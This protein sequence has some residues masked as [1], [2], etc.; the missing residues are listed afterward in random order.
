VKRHCPKL[1]VFR[2][3]ANRSAAF[4]SGSLGFSG[5]CF[6]LWPSMVQG[7]AAD[8]M[9]TGAFTRFEGRRWARPGLTQRR[10]VSTLKQ[11]P[12]SRRYGCDPGCRAW[13]PRRPTARLLPIDPRTD[14]VEKRER[15]EGNARHNEENPWPRASGPSSRITGAEP[16]CMASGC[17]CV[18][19]PGV[20]LCPT[21][22]VRVAALYLPDRNVGFLGGASRTQPHEAVNGV[23]RDREVRG[24]RRAARCRRS[25]SARQRS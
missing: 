3:A 2:A 4:Q 18:P 14:P 8:S 7:R 5:A 9:K 24:A 11:S 19:A 15:P 6:A 17:G 20:S 10:C 13:G 25:R 16:A 12:E 22:A 1:T 21:G 23:R